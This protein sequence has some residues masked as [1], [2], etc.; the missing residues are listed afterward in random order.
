MSHAYVYR[1]VNAADMP[2]AHALSVHLKW[3]HREEDWAMVQRT[4]QGFVAEYDGQL[5]GVAFAC[6]QGAYSS[7]GLVIVSDEHQGKGIGRQLMNLC[8]DA[9]APRTPILNATESGAPLY[10]SMGFI[11]FARIQQHQG[12]PQTPAPLSLPLL[13]HSQ[14][15]VLSLGEYP[16]VIALANAGSGLD[17]TQVL[18]DLLPTAEQVVGIEVL[19]Q[20]KGCAL[21]RRFGRGHIIGPVVAQ[22]LEQAQQLIT[23]L[24]RLIPDAFV[25]FDILA[26]SGLADWLERLGLPCVD[27][28]PRMVLGT[29]PQSRDGIKQFALVTQAIG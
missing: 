1:T 12:V 3:P 14:C 29:P 21:L 23:H 6:H 9:A 11:D 28:A 5:V 10:K 24:L 19:G 27:R 26:E 22:N 7:I 4:S 18:N 15:R 20:L 17:R 16:Q 25:R 8:L 2:A 13:N